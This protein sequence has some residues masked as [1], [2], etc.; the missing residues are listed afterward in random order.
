[1]YCTVMKKYSNVE[2]IPALKHHPIDSLGYIRHE[3]PFPVLWANWANCIWGRVTV[4]YCTLLYCTGEGQ[5][6]ELRITCHKSKSRKIE[7]LAF[8]FCYNA[9]GNHKDVL[10][11]TV[12]YLLYCTVGNH[13]AMMVQ[14]FVGNNNLCNRV[15]QNFVKMANVKIEFWE[16][17][18]LCLNWIPTSTFLFWENASL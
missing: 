13:K 16:V 11:C 4:L 10:Y 3:I 5:L 18:L 8:Y 15:A 1:M 14:I 17:I 2:Y 7:L 6:W 9:V 12:L